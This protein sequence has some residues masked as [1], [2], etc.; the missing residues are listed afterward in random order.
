MNAPWYGCAPLPLGS[1]LPLPRVVD[2]LARV[3]E[4][5]YA[6]IVETAAS[7]HPVVLSRA[8]YD[9]LFTASSA[10][11]RLLRRTLMESAPTSAGRVAALGADHE[12]YPLFMDGPAEEDYA[13]CMARPDVLVS[14]TGPKFLEFN[15]GSGIGGVVDTALHSAAWVAAFGGPDRM[16]FRVVDPLAVR[17][18]IFVK[19]A[20]DLGVRPAVAV[21]GSLRDYA[22]A[23]RSYFELQAESLRRRGLEAEFFE[24]EDL[25]EAVSSS[26]YQLGLR[27][28]TVLEWRSRGIG[29]APV[30]EAL[31]AGCRL[32]ASQS[33]YLIANK[34]V[35]GWVSE[36]RPWMTDA[37]REAVA[38]YLPW[39]RVVSDRPAR[40]RGATAPVGELL[41]DHPEDFV[42]KPAIGMSGQ[43]VLIGRTCAPEVWRRAVREAVAAEDHIVQ[44]YVEPAPY[45]ME[46]MDENGSATHREEVFPVYSPF[47]FDQRD[48][49]CMVRYLSPEQQGVVSINGHG[50]LPNV[51]VALR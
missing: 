45:L 25:P 6:H 37:D 38:R 33:A 8:S 16:P 41:L 27:H 31:D 17:D 35:L 29:F 42:L 28:F 44:E 19:A 14:A 48:G 46:F 18:E 20:R 30:R 26:R 21:V 23:P 15:I 34:K 22:H 51:A 2:E 49:G 4:G 10:L 36:G 32:L 9:E 1:R 13:T 3:R 7:A 12:M 50:A 43:Q 11:L 24:P 5:E 39:T 40:W 47:L